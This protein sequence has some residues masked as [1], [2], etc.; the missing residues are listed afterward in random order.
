M[1]A[2]VEVNMHDQRIPAMSVIAI[3]PD[4]YETIRKV[5]GHLAAQHVADQL[6]IV[7][8]APSLAT[9]EADEAEWQD[10]SRVQVV[11]VGLM[12]SLFR[13]RYEGILQAT[14]PV[15]AF[16]EDHSYPEPGWA[17][18]LIRAH[19]QPWAAVGPMM[20]NGNPAS[21]LS[22]ADYLIGYSPWAE[23]A[24]SGV[25]E[26]LPGNNGSYKREVL[27]SYGSELPVLLQSETVLHWDLRAK[28]YQLYLEPAAVTAHTNFEVWPIWVRLMW[29]HG[30]V[31]GAVRSDKWAMWRRAAYALA[32]PLIP[33]VRLRRILRC[34]RD[35]TELRRNTLRCLPLLVLG[36]AL[37][38]VGEM[39][40]YLFSVGQAVRHLTPLEFM[41]RRMSREN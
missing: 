30:R 11:E 9:L 13:A 8:V 19:R 34:D 37:S 36:L 27:L 21:A 28:G 10:F 15:V 5:V 22:W 23:P 26:H 17:E 24:P 35:S 6:E 39:T 40:G 7:I 29:L 4:S 1:A 3:T 31:F 25:A 41:H 2:T 16:A 38:A 18:A 14:A 20:R 12:D 32:S 33:L